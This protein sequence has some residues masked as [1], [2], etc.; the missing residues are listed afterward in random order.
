MTPREVL[1]PDAL[2]LLQ[3]VADP[4]SFAAAAR[5]LGLVPSALTYRV[6][7]IE[8]A[9]DVLLFD[10]GAQYF[11]VR[12]PRFA[13]AL[14]TAPRCAS[15]GAR[16][17]CACSTRTAASPKPPC[18]RA[19]RIGSRSPAWMRWSRIGRPR[20]ATRS[21]A[22]QVTHIE[23]DAL[24]ARRWQ[25]RTAGA[26]DSMHVYSGFDAVLL[27]VPPARPRALLANGSSRRSSARRSKR[28]A[29]RPAG[30]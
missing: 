12:D 13:H 9:L 21:Y 27:A 18:P 30:P 15:P 1:T 11:T 10:S 23:R 29:S 14:A 19:S 20:W 3:T 16:T 17:S 4:G 25:L 26:D 28:C 5:E 24:D 8:D 22:T 7:Q 6:R 2:A